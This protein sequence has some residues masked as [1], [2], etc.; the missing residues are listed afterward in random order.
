MTVKR[1]LQALN[2]RGVRVSI[3]AHDKTYG[4]TYI[5]GGNPS[6]CCAKYGA[7]VVEESTILDGMLVIYVV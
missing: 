3:R 2:L 4:L 7:Y 5:G 1:L 6:Y